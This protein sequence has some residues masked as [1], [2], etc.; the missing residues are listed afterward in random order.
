MDYFHIEEVL[1]ILAEDQEG[2]EL[3]KIKS[4]VA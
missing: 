3:L 1:P 2:D 4:T